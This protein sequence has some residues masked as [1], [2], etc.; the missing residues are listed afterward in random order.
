VNTNS[1]QFTRRQFL[2]GAAGLASMAAANSILVSC[3]PAPAA[4]KAPDKVVWV[5]PRGTLDVMDDYNMWV[6]Q[7]LGY[8]K[9]M[10]LEVDMQGGPTDGSGHK[11]VA[12]G[13]ADVG[14]PSPGVLLSAIDAGMPLIMAWEMMMKQVFDF[15]MPENTTI[16]KVQDLAGKTIALGSEGWI[17]IVDGML[18]EAGVDPKSVK[19]VN[20]GPQWGQAAALGQ[21]DAALAWRGLQ[22]EWTAAGMKLKFLVGKTFS[23]HPANGYV[24]KKADLTDPARRDI[25]NR[26]FKA[27]AMGLHFGRTN[28]Q[29]AAQITYEA[30]PVVREKFK[31]PQVALDSMWELGGNYFDGDKMG[32]G[33]GYSNIDG[34]NSYI[35]IVYKLGT[36]KTRPKT[37]DVVTNDLIPEANKFDKA[38]V[39]QDA[40]NY[41]VSDQFKKLVVHEL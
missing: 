3:A 21:A 16:T 35:D 19:Y 31:D 32:K 14:Y 8:F 4:S 23:K 5:T 11:L 25:M 36:I 34:W 26:F 29:A 33:Y 7:K 28:P 41:A 2:I 37:E 17:P 39:E 24:I 18:I 38:K 22:T 13:K 20:V 1:K 9:Q 10:N 30:L 27:V 40:K 6:S 15:A 12:E